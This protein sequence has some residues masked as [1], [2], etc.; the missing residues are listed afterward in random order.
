MRRLLAPALACALGA[1]WSG[2]A[3]RA[4]E[5]FTRYSFSLLPVALFYHL[6]HNLMHLATEGGQVVPL[7][8]DPLG[9]GDDLLGTASVRVGALV[10]DDALWMMQVALILI[11]HVF[12]IV[13]AHRVGHRLY[14][15]PARA[16][17][18]LAPV[19]SMMVLVSAAGLGLMHLDMNMRLGRM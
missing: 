6:A 5:L 2:G 13:V 15:D 1:R 8:S 16:R 12:G 10:S 9:Q 7:L 17:R 4:R 3:H 11:G 18:S 14:P 19:F